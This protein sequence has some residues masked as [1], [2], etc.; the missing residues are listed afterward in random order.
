MTRPD[1][2]T[3][4]LIVLGAGCVCAGTAAVIAAF[5]F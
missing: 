5:Y 4:A 3:I 2:T 1:H